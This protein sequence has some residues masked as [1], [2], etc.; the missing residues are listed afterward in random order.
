MTRADLIS[1]LMNTQLEEHANL[2]REQARA[3][4]NVIFRAPQALCGTEKSL[5]CRLGPLESTSKTGS[6]SAGGS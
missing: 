2:T 6:P 4:V 3:V 5:A 1:I